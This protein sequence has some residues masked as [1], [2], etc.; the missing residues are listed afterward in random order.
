M[1]SSFLTIG[2]LIGEQAPGRVRQRP[3]GLVHR[4]WHQLAHEHKSCGRYWSFDRHR[5]KSSAH[6]LRWSRLAFVIPDVA[7]LSGVTKR[8]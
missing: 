8:S 5:D 6:E 7:A 1:V 3:N 2:F 4:I